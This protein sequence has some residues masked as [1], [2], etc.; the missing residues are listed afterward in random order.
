MG[1]RTGKSWDVYRGPSERLIIAIDIGTTFSGAS[2]TI[3]RPG[4]KPKIIDVGS[5]PSQPGGSYKVPSKVI[6]SEDGTVLAIGSETNNERIRHAALVTGAQEARWWKLALRKREDE[7][8]QDDSTDDSDGSEDDQAEAS[9]EIR[10]PVGKSAEDVFTD[11]L[12]WMVD[13]LEKFI[14]SHHQ[15]GAELVEGTRPSRLLVLSHPNGW[16]GPQQVAMRRAAVKARAVADVNRATTLIKFVSEAEAS[17]TY[18]LISQSMSSWTEVNSNIVIVDAGG[19]TIDVTAYRIE[20]TDPLLSVKEISIP[21]CLIEGAITVDNRAARLLAD[22]LKGTR[23]DNEDDL[24]DILTEFVKTVK[25]IFSN[26]RNPCVL[27]I[28][29]SVDCDEKIGLRRG[30]LVLEGHEVAAL[31]KRSINATV[32]SLRSI[33]AE[34]PPHAAK[35]VAL[36]G[37]YS[38]NAYFRD[39]LAKALGPGVAVAKPDNAAAKAVA[40][41]AVAWA[42]DGVVTARVS[43]LWYG[44]RCA[45]PFDCKN[46][47]HTDRAKKCVVS[48]DGHRRLPNAFQ[49][50][51]ARKQEVTN[52]ELRAPFSISRKVAE[53]LKGSFEL[54]VYRG[55]NHPPTFIDDQ[56]GL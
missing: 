14:A 10:I 51:F 3:L 42:I 15:G 34:Y 39:S 20:T 52:E 45:I 29:N 43:K 53:D 9:R 32:N 37:G 16:S 46:A 17:L 23:W 40:N 19:G 36:V 2:Y 6:Y 21:Q 38:E 4:E 41:G 11:F 8:R 55:H 49:V 47:E 50:L 56:A 12:G 1:V 27:K 33:F 48:A 31:F 26:P 25:L 22:R 28:G 5:Y 35:R 24:E 7:D 54:I 30:M 13:C 44:V 18:S